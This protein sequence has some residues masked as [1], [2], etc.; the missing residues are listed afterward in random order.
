MLKRIATLSLCILLAAATVLAEGG[1]FDVQYEVTY[2]QTEAR[3]MVSM[4]N[5]FRTGSDAWYWNADNETKTWCTDL[6]PLVYDAE[7][8]AVAM[9]RAAEL[10]VY[11]A[12]QRPD[13]SSCYTAYDRLT[14]FYWSAGENI[15]IGYNSFVEASEVFT[16]WQETNDPYEGQGHRR[17][18]LATSFNRVGFGYA[19]IGNCHFWT[20]EFA[21]IDEDAAVPGTPVNTVVTAS[22]SVSEDLVTG[23]TG[24]APSSSQMTLAYAETVPM[25]TLTGELVM[26]QT[27]P[28]DRTVPVSIVTSWE[29]ADPLC[30]AVSEDGVTGAALGS[31]R[32]EGTLQGQSF[33]LPVTVQY[34][35]RL[36][37]DAVLPEQL[38]EL[39]GEALSGIAAKAVSVPDSLQVLGSRVFAG[40]RIRQVTFNGDVFTFAPDAFSG[41]PAGMV[42]FCPVGSVADS[43]A[44]VSGITLIRVR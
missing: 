7:L 2:N 35:D 18:M 15:A 29:S 21:R 31:T 27:W 23:L 24:L 33:S 22:V 10:A 17:N 12:H 3:K 32:L 36:T 13:G 14:H 30:A 19:R 26:T 43:L 44:G 1:T 8:E 40:S 34:P 16:A 5:A 20:Q 6:E 41:C 11:Y 28:D 4:I 42:V 9:Q 37:P 38:T 39:D 25:P